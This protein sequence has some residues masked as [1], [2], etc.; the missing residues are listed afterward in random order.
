MGATAS[1]AGP[2]ERFCPFYLLRTCSLLSRAGVPPDI[3][4][5][6]GTYH[7]HVHLHAGPSGPVIDSLKGLKQGCPP[8]SPPF[9]VVHAFLIQ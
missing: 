5:L 7:E 4:A 1:P 9:T 6:L 3:I 8:G 2:P